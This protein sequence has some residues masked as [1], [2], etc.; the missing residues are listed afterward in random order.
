MESL[1]K[2]KA[3]STVDLLVLTCSDQLL[4]MLFF[5][6]YLTSCLYKEVNSTGPSVPSVRVPCHVKFLQPIQGILKGKYHCAFDLLFDWF[7]ISCLTTDNFCSYLQNRLIQT[8]QTGGQRYS[9]TSPFSIPWTVAP[10]A[11]PINSFTLK[12]YKHAIYIGAVLFMMMARLD[13]VFLGI[14]MGSFLIDV[15]VSI[16]YSYR[17]SKQD[18]LIRYPWFYSPM[19]VFTISKC[20]C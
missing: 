1:L 15:T 8:S 6:F 9:D 4:L 10:G 12:K 3:N 19:S 18:T 13:M 17:K 7:G 5:L 14:V 16:V 2:G 11:N 20:C